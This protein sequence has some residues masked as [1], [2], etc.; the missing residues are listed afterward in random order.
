[1]RKSLWSGILITGVL[2]A[3]FTG[4]AA[5]HAQDGG[6][7]TAIIE[8][9]IAAAQAA[10]G[11][12]AADAPAL[13]AGTGAL[14]IESTAGAAI[15]PAPFVALDDVAR[16]TAGGLS[17]A[18]GTWGIGVLRLPGIG[19]DQQLDAVLFGGATLF[20]VTGTPT[21]PVCTATS[22]GTVNVRAEPNTDA[23]ILGQLDVGHSVPVTG[24]LADATWW[25][26]LWQGDTAWVYAELVP[27]DCDPATMLIVDPV[28]GALSG[29]L[30]APD[31]QNVRLESDLSAPVCADAPH[32]G[33]LV[34]SGPVG[35]SWRVDGVRLRIEGTALLQASS[36][37]V[38][39]VQV[40]TGQVSVETEGVRRAGEAG[41]LLRVP[42]HNGELASLPGPGLAF[43]LPDAALAPLML[44][45][46]TVAPPQPNSAV[47]LPGADGTLACG[48]L[49]QQV[50]VLPD[51][52]GVAQINVQAGAQTMRISATAEGGVSRLS[53][54]APGG[55][56][57]VLT[58]ADGTGAAL[59]AD[60]VG[61]AG[62]RYTF[63]AAG[64]ASAVRFGLT[65]DLPRPTPPPPLQSC[66]VVLMNWDTVSGSSVRF[67]APLGAQVSV[68]ATHDLPSQGAAQT[69]Q[70]TTETGGLIG[71]AAFV[72]FS[73]RQAAGPLEVLIPQDGTYVITWDGDPF[74][75]LSIEAL[76]MPPQPQP[77]AAP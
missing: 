52:Q 50:V 40:L 42:L 58:E 30:P 55:T 72:A 1:M 15:N 21:A 75:V 16:V 45:P 9:A 36:D 46:D 3:A 5:S 33:L 77:T 56:E 14:A 44:L 7:C 74:N 43:T 35:A 18:D 39:A 53:W 25:R 67:I 69:L 38:L 6:S 4:P 12:F 8:Q 10:C 22:I 20:N 19:A 62:G 54:Q 13:C 28:T 24:R 61:P 26:I 59:V 64:A 27:A 29:G 76:C 17:P 51:A 23:T 41:Q 66:D 63:S 57:E 2:L 70:V 37:D 32:G 11:G 47:V 49:P 48:L 65:C 60:V 68:T 31:F 34:Q 71:E 73:S